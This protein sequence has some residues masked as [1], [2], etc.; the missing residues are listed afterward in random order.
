M[1]F[2]IDQHGIAETLVHERN[3]L[4]VWGNIGSLSKVSQ[5]FN[6]RRQVFEWIL[7]LSFGGLRKEKQDAQ[8]Q[9]EFHGWQCY[10]TAGWLET[11]MDRGITKMF[12]AEGT[13]SAGL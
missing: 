6:V 12:R 1:R 4:V 10:Q 2:Q 3:S 8:R 9:K 13:R 5:Q 7:A 11:S